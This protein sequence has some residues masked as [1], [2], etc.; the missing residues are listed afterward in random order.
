MTRA[1]P[2]TCDGWWQSAGEHTSQGTGFLPTRR[3]LLATT[4][5][6]FAVGAVGAYA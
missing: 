2:E 3:R 5:T 4:A 1:M 6:L